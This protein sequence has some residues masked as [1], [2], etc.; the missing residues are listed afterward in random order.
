MP[1]VPRRDCLTTW[2][3]R[4]A[5]GAGLVTE[6]TFCAGSPYATDSCSGDSGGPIVLMGGAEGA[7]FGSQVGIVS[8]GVNSC[9]GNSAPGVYASL[10]D[11]GNAGWIVQRLTAWGGVSAEG[12]AVPGDHAPETNFVVF[13]P[14]I[15]AVL[16]F[17]VAFLLRRRGY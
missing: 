11:P 15:I 9:G 6:D 17:F 14:L 5:G 13:L 7:S 8:H 2:T 16:N 1:Y 10:A 3:R 4:V 12:A